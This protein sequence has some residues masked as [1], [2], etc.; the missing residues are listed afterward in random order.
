[1][2][3]LTK[4][5]AAI[6][7]MA[8]ITFSAATAQPSVFN[9]NLTEAQKTNLESGKTVIRN[10]KSTKYFSLNS[11]NAGAQKAMKAAK[12]LKPSYL[13][14]VIQVYPYA[15]HENLV[16]K[17]KTLVMDIPSYAGIPY[18]SERHKK[19]FDLYSSAKITSFTTSGN[20]QHATAD[21]EMS[22]FG[23]INTKIDTETAADY[24]Y[25]ESTNLNVLRYE[26]KIK[27]VDKKCMKSIVT[28]FRDGDY[29]VLYGIGAVDAPSVFFLR[30][31]VETSF[32]NR[33][34][35]FCS[36]FFKKLN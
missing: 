6:F 32:M 3:I 16:E 2:R 34:K 10:L 23:M 22:P 15:G 29:W 27:C 25:Y 8:L 26:D 35:T 5:S 21:L 14:E 11:S 20:Q 28:I 31:R 18:Y 17:F 24:F 33:I 13:A 7:A 9:S 4:K 30:D 1:M 12:D 19:W 36:F